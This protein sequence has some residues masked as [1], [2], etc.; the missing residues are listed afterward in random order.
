MKKRSNAF[1]RSV[2]GPVLSKSNDYHAFF[3]PFILFVTLAAVAIPPARQ[4][5]ASEA[6]VAITEIPGTDFSSK[7]IIFKKGDTF[8]GILKGNGF[9]D[10]DIN[11]IL[12]VLKKNKVHPRFFPL[13]TE[14]IIYSEDGKPFALDFLTDKKDTFGTLFLG[15]DLKWDFSVI[16]VP[17]LKQVLVKEFSITSSLYS[18][19]KTIDETDELVN[20]IADVFK[21]DID[22]FKDIRKDDRIAVIFEKFT[23]GFGNINYGKVL[24]VKYMGARISSD[25]YF[26]RSG[27]N[28]GYFDKDGKNKMKS[29]LKY[30]LKFKRISSRYTG[31]RYHPVLKVYKPHHGI[32]YSAPAGTPVY[33][34]GDGFVKKMGWFG[35]A[36]KSVTI[37]HANGYETIYNHFSRYAKGLRTG[38]KVKTGEVIGYVGATGLATGPH[39]DFRVKK[40]GVWIN[41]NSLKGGSGKPLPKEDMEGYLQL[42]GIYER[43]FFLKEGDELAGLVKDLE[44]RSQF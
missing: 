26:F 15:D 18:A 19:V 7:N 36:G 3:I 41:P 6:V 27:K 9:E 30:P 43:M 4:E 32:D 44:A 13:K 39:L 8:I 17:I 28:Q 10:A 12:E 35:G 42:I 16:T 5:K 2:I 20:N 40:Q 21:W 1:F 14:F 25:A 33:T 24:A 38:K 34:V 22:F 31:K 37:Q 11:N 29:F 23:G